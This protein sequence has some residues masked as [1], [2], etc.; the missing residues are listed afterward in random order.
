MEEKV[1]YFVA[2]MYHEKLG[3]FLFKFN[4]ENPEQIEEVILQR[5]N[6]LI[7]DVSLRI[8][9]GDDHMMR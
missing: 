3:F 5:N 4:Y 2:N 7:E 8:L 6:L 1:L 9:S